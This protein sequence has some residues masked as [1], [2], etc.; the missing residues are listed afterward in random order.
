MTIHPL[1]DVKSAQ[2]GADTLIWQ[3]VVI[4]EKAKIGRNCTICSHVFIE[5]DVVI[6]DNVTIK[7]GVQL[8]DGIRI[9]DNVFVGPNATFTNDSVPRSKSYPVGFDPIHIGKGASIG[10]NATIIG[11]R[12]IGRFAL[13]GAGAV[14]NRDVGD[15]CVVV[16]NPA[17]QIGYISEGKNILDMQLRDKKDGT[18]YVL[19]KGRLETMKL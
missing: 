1:A 2:I 5:N 19:I 17:R 14:V 4:L 10:A 13:I 15:Y 16:G 12:R 6:G 3:Y 8:W 11:S 9:E 7:N 18:Q